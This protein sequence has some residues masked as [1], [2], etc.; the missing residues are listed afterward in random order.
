[1][2]IDTIIAEQI[3]AQSTIAVNRVVGITIKPLIK[4]IFDTEISKKIEDIIEDK[5]SDID[6]QVE[7]LIDEIVERHVDDKV[8][9]AVD[10]YMGDIDWSDHIDSSAVEDAVQSALGDMEWDDLVTAAV[11][12]RTD[13]KLYELVNDAVSDLDMDNIVSSYRVE[14]AVD[15]VLSR[16]TVLKDF[17]KGEV[18]TYMDNNLSNYFRSPEGTAMLEKFFLS[19]AGRSML[20]TNLTILLKGDNIA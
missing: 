15:D 13:Q 17:V 4:D 9:E 18:K 16:G 19:Y 2:T 7:G 8:Q 1:M 20:A 6:T 3:A 5:A 11:E 14:V 12:D 10:N